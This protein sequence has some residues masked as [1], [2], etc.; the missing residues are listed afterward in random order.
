M[1]KEFKK[2]LNELTNKTIGMAMNKDKIIGHQQI[3]IDILLE[4][5]NKAE[6]EKGHFIGCLRE[7]QCFT[8]GKDIYQPI[9]N[10]INEYLNNT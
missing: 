9:N 7:L 4:Q 1:D 8:G 5:Q 2:R 10:M 6:N 3:L